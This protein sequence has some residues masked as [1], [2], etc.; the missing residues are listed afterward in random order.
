MA[1]D[2]IML[3][4]RLVGSLTTSVAGLAG[5]RA[6]TP[7]ETDS[8][9]GRFAGLLETSADVDR[10]HTRH[11]AYRRVIDELSPD[12]ARIVRLFAQEGPQPALDV[13]TKRPFGRGEQLIASGITMIGLQAGC[14]ELDQVRASLDNLVRLGLIAF[15]DEPIAEVDGYQVLEA[16]PATTAAL[17]SVK[18]A[19][20][21][22]RSIRLTAFGR[23]FCTMCG[24]SGATA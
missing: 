1:N 13:R 15:S 9:A 23:N 2:L 5:G 12:E 18:R 3:A 19:A 24:L 16:Q 21:L 10:R 4:P 20:T 11:P 6:D 22:H 7:P 17:K 14:D 8:I